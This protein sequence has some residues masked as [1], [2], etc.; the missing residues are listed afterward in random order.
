MNTF[1]IADT[2]FSVK[3]THRGILR[4]LAD[5]ATDGSPELEIAVTPEE[6]EEARQFDGAEE[7]SEAYLEWLEI[8][9][10]LADYLLGKDTLL[11]HGSALALDG[12]VFLFTAPSGTGKSTHARLWRERFGDRVVMVNDD[13]PMLHIGDG[14]VTVYGTPWSGKHV[15]DTNVALPL[16]ALCLLE[17][18]ETNHV[19]PVTPTEA[20]PFLLRQAYL[21]EALDRVL[22]LVTRL[23]DAVPLFRLGCNMEPE[24]AEIAYRGLKKA[25]I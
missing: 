1:R 6:L 19:D 5:Y 13:K 15:L 25:Q 2:V 4:L 11:F 24:A 20:L 16:H 3:T 10:K 7:Y 18:D 23:A 21:P 17:R 14:G 12:E 22:P 8:H 9:R